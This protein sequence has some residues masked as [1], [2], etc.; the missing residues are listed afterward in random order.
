MVFL[1][2]DPD[3]TAYRLLAWKDRNDVLLTTDFGCV[4][5]FV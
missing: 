5:G 2:E 3:Q 1:T 4:N